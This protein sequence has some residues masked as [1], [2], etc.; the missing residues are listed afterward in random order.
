MFGGGEKYLAC[1]A[2]ALKDAR[3]DLEVEIA[4]PV[5]VDRALVASRLAVD[6]DGIGLR[7]TFRRV[8]PLHRAANKIGALRPLRDR[9]L[10]AQGSRLAG[11]Y[12]LFL[13]MV[14]GIP[15]NPGSAGSVMLCQFPYRRP[16]PEVGGFAGIVCQSQYVRRWVKSYWGR[17]AEV[18]NPPVDL[19]DPAPSLEDKGFVI[20]SVGRFFSGGHGKRQDVMVEEFRRLVDGGLGGWELHLA[21]SV[22]RDAQHRGFYER[23]AALARG[24]PIHLHPDAS[25]AELQTLHRRASIYW[26]AAG[27]EVV[28]EDEPERLEHFGMTTAEAMGYGAVP[29]VYAAGGQLEIVTDR[30][31]GR[32]WHTREELRRA[33]LDLVADPALRRSL[34]ETARAT[35]AGRFGRARFAASL[36]SALEPWL[37]D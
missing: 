7:S 5:P 29:V 37:P 8:T 11:G 33:T 20:L 3:P 31:D 23:V 1:A 35:A 34:G 22:H 19:P 16:G 17:D 26:H 30:H 14:Y 36:N 28:E 10:S 15:V 27:F 18:V 21:G 2:R 32:L 4:A 24:Y 6:L 13:P 25:H 12:D 9:V